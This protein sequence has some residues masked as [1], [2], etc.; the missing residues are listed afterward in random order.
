MSLPALM[1]I[2]LNNCARPVARNP[3]TQQKLNALVKA[4]DTA[5]SAVEKVSGMGLEMAVGNI[6]GSPA[7]HVGNLVS[8][9]GVFAY[10][11]AETASKIPMAYTYAKLGGEDLTRM[12]MA[13]TAAQLYAIPQS[14]KEAILVASKF[15]TPLSDALTARGLDERM[16]RSNKLGLEKRSWS[17]TA[18]GPLATFFNWT[19]NVVNFNTTM[20]NRA[21][22]FFKILSSRQQI[23]MDAAERSFEITRRNANAD[24]GAITEALMNSPTKPMRDRALKRAEEN[25]FTDRIPNYS[26]LAIGEQFVQKHPIAKPVIMFTRA[27]VRVFQYTLDRTPVLGLF[28]PR[29][30]KEMKGAMLAGNKKA[31][32]DV[33][34]R[35][36]PSTVL[37]GA[38]AAYMAYMQTDFQVDGPAPRNAAQRALW[39]KDGHTEWSVKIGDTKVPMKLMGPMQIPFRL[40]GLWNSYVANVDLDDEEGAKLYE[41]GGALVIAGMM[42]YLSDQTWV[43]SA[44][45]FSAAIDDINRRGDF[46]RWQMWLTQF[47]ASAAIPDSGL[48]GFITKTLDPSIKDVRSFEDAVASKLPWA[49]EELAVKRGMYGQP[50]Q[51]KNDLRKI[52]EFFVPEMRGKY[53]NIF[54]EQL[55]FSGP[56]GIDTANMAYAIHPDKVTKELNDM[57]FQVMRQSR[58][59]QSV[60]LT[61]KEYEALQIY[62]ARPPGQPT[63]KQALAEMMADPNYKYKT[64]IRRI[65]DVRALVRDYRKAGKIFLYNDT[66]FDF[67]NRL[68]REMK[69]KD[70]RMSPQDYVVREVGE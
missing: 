57:K 5:V 68:D 43:D 61:P 26:P 2:L 20:L 21:D 17:T 40:L 19:G 4:T 52:L 69:A 33:A 37:A 6:L 11:I 29:N 41:T 28:T 64:D 36:A 50:L 49:A 1:R 35:V 8:N 66:N 10:T 53:Y 58:K 23:A 31:A 45:T 55:D 12:Y 18:T 22:A 14:I 54:G 24:P 70:I 7:T 62:S 34:G 42:N 38:A 44:L 9:A 60:D 51:Y 65:N 3:Q 16:A 30:M 67:K 48:L 59:V 39:E 13:Q 32:F 46:S 15:G 63:L 56:V 27:P 47:G 25:T